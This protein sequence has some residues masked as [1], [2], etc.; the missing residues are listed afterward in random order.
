MCPQ[1]AVRTRAWRL[2][3][4]PRMT[5]SRPSVLPTVG[6]CRGVQDESLEASG[7]AGQRGHE[8]RLVVIHVLALPVRRLRGNICPHAFTERKA[9]TALTESR[10]FMGGKHRPG[11][12]RD[13]ALGAEL[14]AIRQAADKSLQEVATAIQWNV[15]TLS[16][17]E[18]GQRHISS[19]AVMGLAMIYRLPA[20][21]RDELVAWA[22]KPVALGW[23]DRPLPG[24]PGD[25]GA[26]ASYEHEATRMTEWCPGIIPGL[27]Q[28]PEYSAVTMRGTGV[29]EHEI[30]PRIGARRQ[31]QQLLNRG[32]VDYLALIGSAA[33]TNQIGGPAVFGKQ[34]RHLLAQ[35]RRDGVTVRVVEASTPYIFTSWYLMNFEQ[36][37]PVVMLEHDVRRAKQLLARPRT[38]GGEL[39]VA[40]RDGAGCRHV[41]KQPVRYADIDNGRHLIAVQEAGQVRLVPASRSQLVD[42]LNHARRTLPVGI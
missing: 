12:P 8:R 10:A 40:V 37:G 13:R 9:L 36:A 4:P 32:E 23:W 28:I 1:V 7:E 11:T 33:L 3:A 19:A 35:S 34:I 30:N 5:R 22:N 42:A 29:P 16:R 6:C 26:L 25:L 14:R 15:S 2:R 18:R 21:R 20:E 41:I 27:L 39:W 31:R 24:V 17:L 38:G